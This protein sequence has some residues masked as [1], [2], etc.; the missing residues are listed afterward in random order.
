MLTISRVE[1]QEEEVL[2]SVEKFASL[3]IPI[4]RKLV[5]ETC[6]LGPQRVRGNTDVCQSVLT[7]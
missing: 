7:S 2:L 1:L 6:P 4:P 3:D 5:G